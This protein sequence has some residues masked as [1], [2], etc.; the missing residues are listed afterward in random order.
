MQVRELPRIRVARELHLISGR[1]VWRHRWGCW[2]RH[3]D[4]MRPCWWPPCTARC[5]FA[6]VGMPTTAASAACR[7]A[8]SSPPPPSCRFQTASRA[9]GCSRQARR[10]APWSALRPSASGATCSATATSSWVR[11]AAV[12]HA[13]VWLVGFATRAGCT[14]TAGPAPSLFPLAILPCLRPPRLQRPTSARCASPSPAH[15]MRPPP[16]LGR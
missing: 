13:L 5:T 11:L 1:G 8:F 16:P 4:V 12:S 9:C 14:C 3:R 2:G 15:Q 7:T 6:A 10:A